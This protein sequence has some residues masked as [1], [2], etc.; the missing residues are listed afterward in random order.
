MAIESLFEQIVDRLVA[1]GRELAAEIGTLPLEDQVAALNGIR[2]ALHEAGPFADQP[3]D[4]V[5][6]HPT[7]RVQANG[8]NPNSV[9]PPEMRLLEESIRADGY[10]Q[11]VVAY[12]DQQPDRDLTVVD[13][14]HRLRVARE[15]RAVREQVHGH[16]P[17][18]RIRP[19]RHGTDDRMASTI[20]HNRARG[21]HGVSPMSAIVA[22][23]VQMGWDNARIARELGMDPDEVLRMKQIT[24]LAALFA[25]EEFSEAWE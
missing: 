25:E 22:E 4:C 3:V 1:R 16:L 8:Y 6:W 10:T 18:T 7:E 13:G 9:A 11:P 14:F 20:R 5:E 2:R 15:S 12:P 21:R 24:G 23:L 17:V 19:G